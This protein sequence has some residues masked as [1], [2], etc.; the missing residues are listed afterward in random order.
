[1]FA[2]LRAPA[3]LLAALFTAFGVQA[4][5]TITVYSQN[6]E[7]PNAGAPA[8]A[9]WGGAGAGDA[10]ATSYNNTGQVGTA[11]YQQVG[12]ADRICWGAG[13]IP[14]LD[15]DGTAGRFS[16]G[17]AR[18]G[19][20]TESWAAGFDPQGKPFLNGQI[21]LA[22]ATPGN[23]NGIQ[24]ATN[25]PGT[26]PSV[27]VTLNFFRLPTGSTFTL[28]AGALTPT[29]S[30]SNPG[31]VMVGGAALTPLPESGNVTISKAASYSRYAADWN[32]HNFSVDTSA[33]APGDRLIIV[34]TVVNNLTYIVFDNLVVTAADAA[35]QLPAISKRFGAAQLAP[36]GTTTL[37]ID[38]AGNNAAALA[39]LAVTDNLPAPL[40]LTGAAPTNTCGGTLNATAGTPQV[41][42]SGGELP[43]G[44][45]QIT[46]SV[47]WPAAQAAL[48]TGS[49]VTN[50]IT[51]GSDFTVTG[52]DTTGINATADLR[53]VPVP[54][55]P[56]PAVGIEGLLLTSAALGG[57]GAYL[58]RRRRKAPIKG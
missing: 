18:N 11:V 28:Q 19:N 16:G 5:S 45:C 9:S 58:T 38:V 6:F 31:I 13:S 49:S 7:A 10:F 4:Q 12:T 20:I 51:G 29:A 46:V 15:P 56:V 21:D 34:G 35:A 23:L 54:P 26:A 37:T 57:L 22:H 17:F 55:Q 33:F 43:A 24:S 2:R 14:M 44:G 3:V 41:A 36:G 8:C 40:V 30:P 42:L 52:V 32:T 53:C 50:T 39:S 1:M 47:E 25:Y 48:C 27:P